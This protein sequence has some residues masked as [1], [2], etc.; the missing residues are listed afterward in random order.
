MRLISYFI[1]YGLVIDRQN[2][3]QANLKRQ[4]GEK[5]KE[6]EKEKK[7]KEERRGKKRSQRIAENLDGRRSENSE[8][9]SRW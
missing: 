6:K 8:N 9:Q 5:S 1:L 2:S 4:R 7:R 3:G